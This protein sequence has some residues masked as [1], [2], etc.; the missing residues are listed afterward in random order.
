MK[1]PSNTSAILLAGGKSS[2]MGTSKAELDFHGV[3]LLQYQVEKLRRLGIEDIVVSG[4]ATTMEGVPFVPDVY[5][6]RGP[7]GGIH[8]GLLAIKNAS[9]LVISVDCPLIPAPFLQK[10]IAAHESG[11]TLAARDGVTEPLI[12]VYD[13]ALA[14]L[15]QEI[16][17]GER[18]SVR[19]LH[20]AV[21]L[22]TVDYEGDRRLLSGCNTPEEYREI[23]A[24]ERDPL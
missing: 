15:C 10:L 18:T 14:G 12:G 21:G 20:D 19:R 16:L 6:D 4:K 3:S 23:L 13:K 1:D 24:Y 2:R 9:A 22:S 11:I 17:Q 5:P 8:A 7:L